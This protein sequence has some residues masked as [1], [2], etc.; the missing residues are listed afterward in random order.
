M[1][2]RQTLLDRAKPYLWNMYAL[3]CNAN[4]YA[5]PQICQIFCC[6]S[7][8][9]CN[10]S[11]SNWKSRQ[12]IDKNYINCNYK[13]IV[14]EIIDCESRL[15]SAKWW[16][17]KHLERWI[18]PH[19]QQN[20]IPIWVV[21]EKLRCICWSQETQQLGGNIA[22]HD[23]HSGFGQYLIIPFGVRVKERFT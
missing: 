1:F 15:A 11:L 22:T 6:L 7:Q 18:K 5:L 21:I 14:K 23:E 20:I 4:S 16:F 3:F 19:K 8:G 2:R 12:K 10:W 13:K 17:Y 9:L